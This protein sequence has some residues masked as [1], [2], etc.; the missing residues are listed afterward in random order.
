MPFVGAETITVIEQELVG[1]DL[2]GRPQV[3][4]EVVEGIRATVNPVPGYV[5]ATL[6]EGERGSHQRRVIT[7]YE[8]SPY[9]DRKNT[10]ASL[11]VYEGEVYEVRDIQSYRKIIPHLSARVRAFKFGEQADR[12]APDYGDSNSSLEAIL[13]TIL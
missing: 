8:L 4:Y 6:P 10:L 5:L 13:E 7:K 11:V 12:Y 2:R 9:S 1:E 3:E